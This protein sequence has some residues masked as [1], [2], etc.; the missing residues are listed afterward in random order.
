MRRKIAR[1]M[2]P[3]VPLESL[4]STA[5]PGFEEPFGMLEACHQRIER[6]VALL[7]RL[8][9]HLHGHGA[10]EQ[11]R[12]AARDVIRYFDLAAPEHHRD[13]E[14]HVFPLLLAAGDEPMAAK[15]R[16]LMDEHRQM[17]Q[18]WVAARQ[19]LQRVADGAGQLTAPDEAALDAFVRLYARHLRTEDEQV[20][21]PA[22]AAMP[23]S[24]LAA[25]SQDMMRRR[26]VR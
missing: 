18:G 3:P 16:E 22:R 8:R 19:V 6:T 1:D 9:A 20:Y 7:E 25:M 4:T 26:G 13:E 24:A 12:Q 11:A 14:R 10:D 21:P 23:A 2:T 15:V 5:S 17:D